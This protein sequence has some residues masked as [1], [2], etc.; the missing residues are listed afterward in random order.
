[1]FLN[2]KNR[3]IKFEELFHGTINKTNVYPRII[4]QKALELNAG[5][6]IFAHNHPSGNIEPS[7]SD[8]IIT[9]RLIQTMELIDVRVLDHVI[10]GHSKTFS[11]AEHGMMDN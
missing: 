4:A 8:K 2:N 3:L 7:T 6:V 10:V 9:S 5:A 1:M 11:M